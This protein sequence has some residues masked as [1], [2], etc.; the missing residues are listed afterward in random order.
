MR[1]CNIWFSIP[2]LV[3]QLNS[4][5]FPDHLSSSINVHW[6]KSYLRAVRSS[7]NPDHSF[8]IM[9]L[10][11]LLFLL[12]GCLIQTAS[13]KLWVHLEDDEVDALGADMGQINSSANDALKYGVTEQPHSWEKAQHVQ[14][15]SFYKSGERSLKKFKI[16]SQ[17][18]LNLVVAMDT[19]LN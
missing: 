9:R 10:L 16:F 11:F 6:R 17:D 8:P 4:N 5:S 18:Y 13:G 12:L 7:Y 1:T 15:I 2:V 14:Q 19:R 3:S